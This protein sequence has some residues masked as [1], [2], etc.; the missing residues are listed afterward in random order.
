MKGFSAEDILDRFEAAKAEVVAMGHQPFSPS[1]VVLEN[2]TYQDFMIADLKMLLDCEAIYMMSGWRASGG[3]SLEYDVAVV[4][5][6][7]I[8]FQKSSPTS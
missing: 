8:M 3:A 5:G 7:T 6:L 4:C 2:P 1:D